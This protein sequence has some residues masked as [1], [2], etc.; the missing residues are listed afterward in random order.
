MKNHETKLRFGLV[1]LVNTVV[2]FGVLFGLT[3]IFGLPKISSNIV[4]TTT[5]FVFSFFANRK[6]TF[7]SNDQKN[8]VKQM[9]SFTVVTLLGLWVLQG[10]VLYMVVPV[11][12]QLGLDSNMSLLLAKILA[13]A[14]SLVWN[15]LLYSKVVFRNSSEK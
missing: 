11:L 10:T 2:D 1:G 6:Y 5:A 4:S 9:I 3:N 7:R 13:T 12:K 8:I 15:Y 14:V